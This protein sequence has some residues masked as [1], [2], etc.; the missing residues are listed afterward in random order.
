M[1]YMFRKIADRDSTS[2][3][4]RT[5]SWIGRGSPARDTRSLGSINPTNF[6][7]V[8]SRNWSMSFGRTLGVHGSAAA[9][10]KKLIYTIGLDIRL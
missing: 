3:K 8:V 7:L 2:F 5:P 4:T 9:I 10:E 1:I 6:I